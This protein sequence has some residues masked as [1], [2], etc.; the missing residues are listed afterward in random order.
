MAVAISM[1][2]LYTNC[3]S[4]ANSAGLSNE[5]IPSFS[6]F[7]F[8]IWPKSDFLKTSMT[9]TGRFQ[10]KYLVQQ[11]NLRKHSPDENYCAAIFKYLRE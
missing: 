3:V 6:W 7:K 2:D 4:A 11:K 10:V 1:R 9:Y 8:Q 5:D